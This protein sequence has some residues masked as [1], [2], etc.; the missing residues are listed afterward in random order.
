MSKHLIKLLPLAAALSLSSL[1]NA[2]DVIDPPSVV[3]KYDD[4]NLNTATGVHR[5]HARLRSAARHV[6][7][8]L[9]GSVVVRQDRYDACVTDAVERSVAKV[10][11][12]NL[13]QFH[14]YGRI[15]AMA[16]SN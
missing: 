4:L 13:T 1:A 3:V 5:L 6:C 10:G 14:R 2:T 12:P 16:A 8:P 11:N 7:S 15:D 9:D